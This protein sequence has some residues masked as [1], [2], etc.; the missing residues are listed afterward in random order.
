MNQPKGSSPG[1]PS[2]DERYNG[3]LYVYGEEANLFLQEAARTIPAQSRVAAYAEGEGRNAVFLAKLGHE[4]TAY[5]YAQAGLRKTEALAVKNGVQ[6]RTVHADLIEDEL[7]VERYDAAVMIFGHFPGKDQYRVLD[8]ILG[9]LKPGGRLLTE[10]YEK[11]QIDYGTGGPKDADWLYDAA[12]LLAW[13]KRLRLK[14]F[15]A[16]EAERTEGLYHSGV[17]HVVQMVAEKPDLT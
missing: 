9:S 5:D 8:K 12:E 13:G 15:F 7:P 2:W 14:H 10:V 4:V 11:T 6:V 16:G 17:C 1:V 3:D